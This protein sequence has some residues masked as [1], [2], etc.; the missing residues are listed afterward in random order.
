MIEF[1]PTHWRSKCKRFS[2][3]KHQILDY[4]YLAKDNSEDGYDSDRCPTF[5]AA[6][7]W[8][9]QRAGKGAGDEVHNDPALD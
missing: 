8:C 3:I 2:I 4:P 9:E 6:V 1:E 5:A 7:A